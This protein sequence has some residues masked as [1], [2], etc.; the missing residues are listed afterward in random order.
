MRADDEV[1]P[2]FLVHHVVG[3]VRVCRRKLGVG[4]DRN[5]VARPDEEGGDV[6]LVLLVLDLVLGVDG[7]LDVLDHVPQGLR[8]LRERFLVSLGRLGDVDEDLAVVVDDIEDFPD[9]FDPVDEAGVVS[10]VRIEAVLLFVRRVPGHVD[11]DHGDFA[12]RGVKPLDFVLD[13]LEALRVVLLRGV[14]RPGLCRVVQRVRSV[15][16]G[17]KDGEVVLRIVERKDGHGFGGHVRDV[18]D[19]SVVVKIAVHEHGAEVDRAHRPGRKRGERR[20][21]N[22][23]GERCA[24]SAAF[25]P[26]EDQQRGQRGEDGGESGPGVASAAASCILAAHA[27]GPE[28]PEA[29]VVG[30][31]SVRRGGR[32]EDEAPA[33][34]GLERDRRVHRVAA[35]AADEGGFEVF[36]RDFGEEDVAFVAAAGS[37]EVSVFGARAAEK[38][39][40]GFGVDDRRAVVVPRPSD[41]PGCEDVA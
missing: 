30:H 11:R 17:R 34:D 23:R 20:Q 5:E 9:E 38:H 15:G 12:V 22:R 32:S 40:A 2:E 39:P 3:A 1:L 21:K 31:R 41:A 37:R 19:D 36:R 13:A 35:E 6:V 14:Q 16:S 26:A 27:C 18:D 7:F 8:D 33:G 29:V 28:I 25:F 4:D 10:D 24:G